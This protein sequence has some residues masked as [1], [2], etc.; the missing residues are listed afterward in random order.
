M[1]TTVEHEGAKRSVKI[2]LEAWEKHWHLIEKWCDGV[3]V[4]VLI[5]GGD[6][7][8]DDYYKDVTSPNFDIN[9]NYQIVTRT[10]I[11]GEV[12]IYNDKP[13]IFVRARKGDEHFT[14]CSGTGWAMGNHDLFVYSAPSI[15]TY[16]ARKIVEEAG[17]AGDHST[18]VSV[19]L[20]SANY[21]DDEK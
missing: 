14:S 21:E 1:K 12:W 11:A 20:S 17:V 2:S 13:W 9:N 19:V 4:Q 3:D 10:P 18:L 8:G 5:P 15:E 6:G 7:N 16:Y